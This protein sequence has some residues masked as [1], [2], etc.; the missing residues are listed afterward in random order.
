VLHAISLYYF[1]EKSREG[2]SKNIM[3]DS[4]Y[5][6]IGASV[7]MHV[8]WN[9][10]ARHVDS[11]ANFLWWGLLAYIIILG[12]YSIWHLLQKLVWS[13]NLIKALSVTAIAYT[14][15]F[16]SLGRAY[17]Y[18]PVALVY[19]LARS[20]P[21]LIVLW[22]W[23]FFSVSLSLWE[24]LEIGVSVLGLWI[25]ATSSRHGDTDKALPWTALA[26]LATSIYSLS[27][28][29]AIYYLEG[30]AEQIGFVTVGFA[31]SF[32]GL[33]FVQY[34]EIK[35]WTPT[36]R[37]PWIF[38]LFGGLFIGAAHVL[39]LRAMRDIPASHVV[40]FTN[41]GIV[42]AVILS[43]VWYRETEQW[44]KRLVGAVIVSVGLLLLGW[45]A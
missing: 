15:Y 43:L 16:V 21:I 1:W 41:A 6:L 8:S 17:R 31:A 44:Q 37:P 5:F 40:S 33:S 25:L 4:P 13:A 32:L 12:P 45:Q 20:S 24:L 29:V 42:V 10:I 34:M 7:I 14:V 30:Y 3:L 39:I 22:A 19:P 11:K 28:K 23:V 9:L 38:I 18:A 27:D 36:D 35:R 26:A 2:V